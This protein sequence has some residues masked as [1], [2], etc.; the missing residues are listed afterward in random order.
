[1]LNGNP[2]SNLSKIFKAL[3]VGLLLSTSSINH[4]ATSEDLSLLVW[5][6]EAIITTYTVNAKDYLEDEKKIAQYFTSDGWIAY[7]KALNE[8]KLPSVI[9]ANSYE[10][11]AVATAP[12]QLITLDP[13]HWTVIMPVLVQYKNLQYQQQQHLKVTLGIT[14]ATAGQGIRGYAITSLQSIVT[15]P[16]CECTPPTDSKK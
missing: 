14:T 9:Q 13:T 8:S 10:V 4:A 1:M 16:L 12:P 15:Q 6:N 3:S 11:T 5:A 7:N 2:M